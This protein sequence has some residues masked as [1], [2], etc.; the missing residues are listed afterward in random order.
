MPEDE[1]NIPK[2]ERYELCR[3]SMQNKNAIISASRQEMLANNIHSRFR[4]KTGDSG[5]T[6]HHAY[7]VGVC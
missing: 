3:L 6:Q 5:K 4:C 1:L 2:G 7:C